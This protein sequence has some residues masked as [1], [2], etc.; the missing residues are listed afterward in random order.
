MKDIPKKEKT[1]I[2]HVFEKYVL[3]ELRKGVQKAI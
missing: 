2:E 3:S 1:E